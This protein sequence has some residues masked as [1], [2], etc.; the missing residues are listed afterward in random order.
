[1]ATA[2]DSMKFNIG[3]FYISFFYTPILVEIVQEQ[4]TI[5]MMTCH[6]SFAARISRGTLRSAHEMRIRI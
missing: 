6:D 4:S 1:M 5:Y 3:V 2:S